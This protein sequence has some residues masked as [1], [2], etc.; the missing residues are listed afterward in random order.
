[1]PLTPE[2][3]TEIERESDAVWKEL[4][5]RRGGRFHSFVP[6]SLVEAHDALVSVQG[7]GDYFVELGSG[8]GAVT[9]VA[10]LL[11]FDAV[12]VEIEP[13]LVEAS[14]VLAE[15][16]DSEARFVEGSFLPPGFR[17][18][19][20]ADGDFNVTYD[21]AGSAFEGSGYELED[22]DLIYAFPWPE[23]QDLFDALIRQHAREDALFLAY[24]AGAGV[25][26]RDPNTD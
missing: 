20:Y 2:L 10:D 19:R 26:I 21:N 13:W 18:E 15:R 25:S 5:E 8:A 12:G 3:L 11:G 14:E 1:M 4:R 16:F 24:C 6:S 9:I 22:F 17:T 7:R 23:E